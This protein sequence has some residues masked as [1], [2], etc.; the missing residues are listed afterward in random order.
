MLIR[1]WFSKLTV[2]FA[3]ISFCFG[4]IR[5]QFYSYGAALS[6]PPLLSLELSSIFSGMSSFELDL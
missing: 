3:D 4:N 2:S 5:Q 6:M 1:L